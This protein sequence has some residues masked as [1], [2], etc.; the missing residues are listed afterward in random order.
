MN[1]FP[2]PGVVMIAYIIRVQELQS[3]VP[4]VVD[5]VTGDLYRRIYRGEA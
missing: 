5:I 4:E 3:L 2:K 1:D